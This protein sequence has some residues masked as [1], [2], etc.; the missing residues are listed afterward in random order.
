[1]VEN[2]HPIKSPEELSGYSVT[3]PESL[4]LGEVKIEL[5]DSGFFEPVC[6]REIINANRYT[7]ELLNFIVSN[8][9]S[10]TPGLSQPGRLKSLKLRISN[11]WV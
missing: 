5:G 2:G 9:Y 4:R 6:S 7:H 11:V 10:Y 1:M 3:S 8:L